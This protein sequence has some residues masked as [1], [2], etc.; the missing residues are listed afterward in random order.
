MS[1]RTGPQPALRASAASPVRRPVTVLFVDHAAGMGGAE[2][3][4]LALLEH[5]DRARVRPVLAAVDGPLAEAARTAGVAVHVLPLVQL[6]GRATAAWRLARGTLAL[7]R[8]ARRV[9]A[10]VV[11]ANVLR[12]A[13][14]A[15]PAA[16]L[17]RRPLVW[18]V[19]DILERDATTARLCRSA[20][21]IVAISRAAAGGLPCAARARVIY[22]PVAVRPPRARSRADLGLPAEGPL[23]AA[24]GRLRAWKGHAAF[25]EAAARVRHADAR[26]VVVGGRLFGEDRADLD[27][28][29]G[30]QA[31]AAALGIA[32]RV[33]WLGHRD[34]VPDLWP[35]LGLLVHTA[36]AE[37]FGRVVAEALV[38]GVPAVAFRDGGVPEIV[39]DGASGVLVAPGDVAG[40]ADAVDRLLGDPDLRRRMGAAG[41]AAARARFDPAAHARAVEAVYDCLP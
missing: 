27:L 17:T 41:Q 32:D 35:H 16:R 15:A 10:D 28:L 9:E 29:G 23:V 38:A 20:A 26:F 7:A 3:S 12:A 21:A 36:A 14:Y 34:D 39:D 33:A 19:R 25:L 4:L 2:H 1:A 24:I 18:H 8:L 37:P 31:Q 40:V 13:V 30:L 5:L 22:N 6:R 11:H